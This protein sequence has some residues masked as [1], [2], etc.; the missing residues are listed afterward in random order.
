MAELLPLDIELLSQD[1]PR[2]SEVAV[3][4]PAKFNSVVLELAA[5]GDV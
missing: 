5:E 2:P 4:A 1:L 3:E